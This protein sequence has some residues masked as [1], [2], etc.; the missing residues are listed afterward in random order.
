MRP[1]ELHS[2]RLILKAYAEADEDRFVEMA[3]DPVSIA[4]MGNS[5][6]N[7]EAERKLFRSIAELYERQD[8]RWFW[9]WGAYDRRDTLIGHVELKETEHTAENE[10]EIVYLIHPD[11]RRKGYMREILRR[12]KSEQRVW[13]K[14]IIAT[15]NPAN[16]SSIDLLEEWGIDE[17][18][19]VTNS[20]SGRP[21][22]KITLVT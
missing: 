12:M 22:L 11:E 20:K 8:D 3:L 14:R 5:S 21:Y 9:I 18:E 1:P 19:S 15:V 2:D 7:P 10:L 16:K 6:G 13:R 17:R 4:F